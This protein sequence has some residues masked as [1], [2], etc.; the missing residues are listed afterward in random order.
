MCYVASYMG[1]HTL[2]MFLIQTTQQ[3]KAELQ[4]IGKQKGMEGQRATQRKEHTD[5]VPPR[6]WLC[7]PTLLSV[8]VTDHV[9]M[10]NY[11]CPEKGIIEVQRRKVM[12]VTLKGWGTE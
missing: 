6:T 10:A 2:E 1:E 3:L 4:A 8:H 7:A 5:N 11:K 9:Q 12:R